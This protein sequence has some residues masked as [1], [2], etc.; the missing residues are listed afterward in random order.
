M[1]LPRESATLGLALAV[2]GLVTARI[3][4]AFGFHV[5]RTTLHE[6]RLQGVLNQEPTLYQVVEGLKGKAPLIA[7]PQGEKELARWVAK[8][9]DEKKDEILEKGR[10]WPITRIFD[11]GDMIYFIYFDEEKIM[12]DFAYISNPDYRVQ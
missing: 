8:W 11:A 5:R 7:S 1:R 6:R 10:R 12:R 2:A 4:E 9:G 3:L